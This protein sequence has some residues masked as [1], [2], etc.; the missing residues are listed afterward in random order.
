MTEYAMY[1]GDK[2]IDID[3]IPSFS[4][5]LYALQ[6]GRFKITMVFTATYSKMR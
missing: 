6:P 3:T 4:I 1:K 2:F 5:Q